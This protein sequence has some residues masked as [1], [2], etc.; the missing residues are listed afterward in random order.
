MFPSEG[1]N[2]GCVW[3]YM[4][5]HEEAGVVTGDTGTNTP[6]SQICTT[7]AGDDRALTLLK[8]GCANSVVG[9]ELA[10]NEK[11][12]QTQTFESRYFPG[13]PR[14]QVEAKKFGMS[15]ETREIKLVLRDIPGFCRDI[16][17]APEKFEKRKS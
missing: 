14:Q 4:A 11:R 9:L 5:G 17:W 13:L 8:R 6:K 1:Y 7:L 10:E 2:F 3:S 12:A 15:L 16:L